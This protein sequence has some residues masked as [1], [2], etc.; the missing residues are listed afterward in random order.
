MLRNLVIW[1]SFVGLLAIPLGC[2]AG[3]DVTPEPAEG[4]GVEADE[5]DEN[6]KPAL[7]GSGWEETAGKADALTGRKGL[8][9]RSDNTS[10]QVWSAE[11]AWADTDT[12]AAR[13]AGMAW[14]EDSG[15]TW[16]EK[17]S[18]WVE[19]L[20]KVEAQSWGKTFKLTTPWG[21]TV[22][23]PALECAEVAIFLRI[24][25]ASWYKL[26]FFLEARDSSGNRLYFGHMGIRTANGRY[27]RMPR[28]RDSYSDYTDKAQAYMAG[29][30]EWPVDTKLRGRKIV[31]SFDDAQPMIGPD[32]HAGAY[33]DEIFLNKRTGYFLLITLTYF[34]SIN[35][36]DS[37]Q[38]YNVKADALRPGD[39]LLE[40]WQA[41]GIGHTLVVLQR[42]N[43]GSI[44]LDGETVPT[45]E[46]ELASGS[47]PRRQPVW[48]NP[49]GS[50]RYFTNNMMGGPGYED[51]RGGLK[52]WR[53]AANVSGRW[54]NIVPAESSDDWIDSRKKDELAARIAR[55]DAILAELTA[56]EKLTALEEVIDG[57]RN[58]L[59]QFPAS[60][61]ARIAREDAFKELYA[62]GAE[63]G[64][65]KEE[66]DK[67]YR[68]LED[69]VFAELEYNKSK[70]CCWNSSTGVMY[71]L[72]MEFNRMMVENP[73]TGECREV[74]TF[75]NRNDAGDGYE[76]FR[77]FAESKGLGEEWVKWSADESCPQADVAEDTEVEHEWTALCSIY[78]G[79]PTE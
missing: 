65:S 49:A 62:T 42:R 41:R 45:F 9:V 47:M 38:T 17:Y 4:F 78:E 13:E 61:S 66:M 55:F 46:A 33:F 32:A 40:R 76:I 21:K 51:F 16:D 19:S 24:A 56:E 35:L 22:D 34:G 23:A 77:E 25:F 12:P 63:L 11:N 8:S 67:D 53:T 36:V 7:G 37:A 71:D 14:G 59:R 60:C 50:K 15:L 79:L 68:R 44:E 26:P 52:R 75:K 30:I 72:V 20:E 31:G 58:H 27:G 5:L 43:L 18:R 3:D 28:F 6:G 73:E 57:K 69:Y 1:F 2:G 54:T 39:V 10:L 70:T 29:E 64:L 74:V 48:D